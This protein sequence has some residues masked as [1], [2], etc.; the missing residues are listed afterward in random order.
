MK[1]I[2]KYVVQEFMPVFVMALG[3]FFSLFAIIDLFSHL[4]EILRNQVPFAILLDYYGSMAPYVF[5]QITPIALL[6]ASLYVLGNFNR[7]KEL[8]AATA[9][10][11]SVR[12]MILPIF[13]ISLLMSL[14]I[15]LVDNT[16]AVKRLGR[17]TM[18]EDNQI[19]AEEDRV[20]QKLLENITFYGSEN[21]LFYIGL[22][23]VEHNLMTDITI[24]E[25]DKNNTVTS[26]IF[27]STASWAQ[28][29]W[30][31][32]H[33][34]I[35]SLDKNGQLKGN[36]FVF[37][38]TIIPIRET[39][40]ELITGISQIEFMNFRE[41][42]A[43]IAKLGGKNNGTT[44][45]LL[46]ELY[47]KTAFPLSCIAI[48]FVGIPLGVRTERGGNVMGFGKSIIIGLS[49]YGMLAVTTGLGKGGLL[50]PLASAWSTNISFMV[51]GAFL[52]KRAANPH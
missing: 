34:M 52:L 33:G 36:P 20:E 41:L 3:G 42:K 24:L 21:R 50:P 51:F 13:F 11:I 26:K 39:P 43:Y 2:D 14:S 15:F 31:F 29:K 45:R 27:A 44:R 32:Y 47:Y 25:H 35:M 28:K 18:I 46:V 49:Y 16:Y 12:R 48:L 4:D 1:L 23:D 22:F 40:N 17:A 5:V 8:L 6:L 37:D 30:R 7:H 19:K 10:G 9:C 38:E